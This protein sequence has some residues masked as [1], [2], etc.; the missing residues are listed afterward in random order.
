[1]LRPAGEMELCV[2]PDMKDI[3][4][5]EGTAVNDAVSKSERG[6]ECD[7]MNRVRK[8][9]QSSEVRKSPFSHCA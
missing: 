1:M 8:K 5:E 6:R 3:T 4:G 2:H 7:E 9:I